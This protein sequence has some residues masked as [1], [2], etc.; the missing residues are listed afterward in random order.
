MHQS[1]TFSECVSSQRRWCLQTALM[2]GVLLG[3]Q[4]CGFHWRGAMTMP[5]VSLRSNFS[6]RSAIGRELKSQLQA[7]GV[8]WMPPP[9]PQQ[10]IFPVDVELTVLS[11]QRERA[12]VGMTATGQ[13]REVQLRVRFKFLLRTGKGR[14]L[15]DSTELL[16]ERDMSYEESLALAKQQ[17]EELLYRDMQSEIVRQLLR[18][19]AAVRGL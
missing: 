13:V 1:P 12:V 11:E 5:F 9:L 6:E 3:L 17:E 16:Q 4:G 14:D 8:Q 10:P 2:G 18:R 15:I 19:L 7:S